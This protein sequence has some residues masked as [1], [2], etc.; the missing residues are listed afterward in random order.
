MGQLHDD[1][2][3]GAARLQFEL[4]GQSRTVRIPRAGAAKALRSW[5]AGKWSARTAITTRWLPVDGNGLP[6]EW[7]R[8]TPPAEA[9]P[10]ESE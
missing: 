3:D 5:S 9:Q 4:N 2:A 10:R 1:E 8:V 6:F 7:P